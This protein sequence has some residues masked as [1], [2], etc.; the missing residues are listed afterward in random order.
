MCPTCGKNLNL[1]ECP[2]EKPDAGVLAAKLK[3]FLKK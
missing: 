1:G 3:P 2:C